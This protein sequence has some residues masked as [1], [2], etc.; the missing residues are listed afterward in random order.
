MDMANLG[1]FISILLVEL[2]WMQPP[3]SFPLS[4]TG[5]TP[6]A[7]SSLEPKT[8]R[9]MNPD[10]KKELEGRQLMWQHDASLHQPLFLIMRLWLH[11]F[12]DQNLP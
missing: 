3:K 6:V 8:S 5:Y 2:F 9:A 1:S 10:R 11:C 12:Q 4:L 7:Y